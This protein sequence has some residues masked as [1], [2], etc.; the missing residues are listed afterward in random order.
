MTVIEMIQERVGHPGGLEIHERGPHRLRRG[1]TSGAGDP[2]AMSRL[3]N[4]GIR[5]T[6]EMRKALQEIAVKRHTSV[7]ALVITILADSI[8]GTTPAEVEFWNQFPPLHDHARD[9]VFLFAHLLA[10]VPDN[11]PVV[12]AIEL[13][14]FQLASQVDPDVKRQRPVRLQSVQPLD[15]SDYW[16][17]FVPPEF[18]R[19]KP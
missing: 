8:R 18:K 15:L 4:L 19:S 9:L 3:I 2:A 10:C 14:L 7:Q 16:K 12:S 1:A 5:G 6:A 13:L 17:L 11:D